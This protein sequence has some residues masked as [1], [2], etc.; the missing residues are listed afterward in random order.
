[1]KEVYG[2][3]IEPHN[4]KHVNIAEKATQILSDAA[5]PG[6]MLVNV[7]PIRALL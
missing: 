5:V 1:M 2:Y 3:E 4:D 7:L 6:A